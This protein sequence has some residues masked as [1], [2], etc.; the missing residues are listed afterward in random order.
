MAKLLFDVGGTYVKY[1]LY[2]NQQFTTGQFSVVDALGKEDMPGALV[3]FIKKY[4]K[5]EAIGFSI[6]GPFDYYNGISQMQHKLLSLYQVDL[7]ALLGKIHPEAK[8]VFVHD[9]VSFM[10]GVLSDHPEFNND[11]VCCV[12]IGTGLG[13]TLADHG[14]VVVNKSQLPYTEIYNIKYRDSI[15]EDYVSAT[16]LVKFA[17]NVGYPQIKNVAEM[18]DLAHKGDQKIANIFTFV[19]MELAEMLNKK[20]QDDH[21]N[22]IIFGGGVSRAWDLL[23][24]GFET[25]CHIPYT[26]VTDA[27]LTPI[28]GVLKVVEEGTDKVY[29]FM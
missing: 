8:I 2:E 29:R 1:A 18:A 19:G 10:L 6:P 9:A 7:K 28:K 27:L 22:R 26:I 5:L 12:T 11:L 21:F 3:E 15:N 4:P 24:S 13:Y 25:M 17:H 16:A 23:K 20:Q 14:R